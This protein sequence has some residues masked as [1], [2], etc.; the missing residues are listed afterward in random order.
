M[1]DAEAGPNGQE[2]G[3]S[4]AAE[5]AL[6]SLGSTIAALAP[7]RQH[8][9][10]TDKERERLALLKRAA[11][12][13]AALPGPRAAAKGDG[14]VDRALL[15][16]AYRLRALAAATLASLGQHAA[17]EMRAGIEKALLHWDQAGD[18]RLLSPEGRERSLRLHEA[19]RGALGGILAARRRTPG[20]LALL[21][22]ATEA[23]TAV[24]A[25]CTLLRSVEV[26]F[27]P[28]V[29]ERLRQRIG[30]APAGPPPE[31]EER[32]ALLPGGAPFIDPGQA[33]LLTARA[34]GWS[35]EGPGADPG[36]ILDQRPEEAHAA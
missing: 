16:E 29:R 27:V 20:L 6:R 18:L 11:E 25:A 17:A 7:G 8:V 9:A 32:E 35:G 21:L 10:L 14:D 24:D 2:T 26:R 15:A 31:Q 3:R 23:M 1:I 19:A 22:C 4:A 5:E 36:P 33:V 12:H 13:V 30:P 34:F 28:L